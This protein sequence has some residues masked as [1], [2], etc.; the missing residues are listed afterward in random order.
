VK[1]KGKT[2]VKQASN[3]TI[4]DFNASG[5]PSLVGF[6]KCD[7]DGGDT[8]FD[9]SG[10]DFDLTLEKATESTNGFPS[11][12][13]MWA[14]RSGYL[15]LKNGDK[16][17]VRGIGGSE[18]DTG[19]NTVLLSCDIINATAL[20]DCDFGTAWD[21]K[22]APEPLD[23]YR[24]FCVSTLGG[25]FV[26]RASVYSPGGGAP[27][28]ENLVWDQ[29]GIGGAT[30]EEA[31]TIATAFIPSIAVRTYFDGALQIE[32][33]TTSTALEVTENAF[34]LKSALNAVAELTVTGTSVRNFQM[35]SFATAPDDLLATMEFMSLNPGIVPKWWEG[36]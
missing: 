6:W 4:D 7:E 21:V 5:T 31:H 15:S 25:V 8:V 9:Y 36:R 2:S 17:I 16:A 23:G 32:D 33:T 28:H 35:W 30:T 24:G 19:T 18:L 12:Q 29:S 22:L 11:F 1:I 10:N 34:A 14:R 13:A 26:G 27:G 20:D 3:V